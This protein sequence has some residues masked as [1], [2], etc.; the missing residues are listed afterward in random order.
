MKNRLITL[1]CMTEKGLA[2]LKGLLPN[3]SY[4][5]D[6]VIG[7]R[8]PNVQNDYYLD[9]KALCS[10]HG[11]TF[12][13]KAD[14]KAISSEYVLA[15]GWR[16]IIKSRSKLV[17]FHDSLLPKYRGFSPIVSALINGDE[18]LGVTAL[19][20]SSEYDKGDIIFQESLSVDYPIKIQSVIEQLA[21]TYSSLVL[22]IVK[23]IDKG[24][25]LSAQI[26]VEDLATYSLWRD[27]G[28]YLIDWSL[29]SSTL[30]RFIN[31]VGFP[32]MGASTYING[33]CFRIFDA[34]VVKDAKIENRDVGKIIFKNGLKPI[35][36]CG[37]GLLQVNSLVSDKTKLEVLDS[38]A[39]RIRFT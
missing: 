24:H 15:I 21:E 23:L 38:L 36:V 10:S 13:D 2:V 26:Q 12:F 37:V 20:A 7:S 33:E 18:E 6:K 14:V 28:D 27:E 34:E 17:V 4:L 30:V 8:D 1:F 39:F 3:H 29:D 32:Y 35:I 31:A 16:W 5:I 19:F 22:K 25:S 11:V 9:I